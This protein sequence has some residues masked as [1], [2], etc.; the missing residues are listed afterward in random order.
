MPPLANCKGFPSG[1][2]I[3]LLDSG[4]LLLIRLARASTEDVNLDKAVV[5]ELN[6]LMFLLS[7]L[8]IALESSLLLL[9][10]VAVASFS[11]ASA[12]TVAAA[13][14]LASGLSGV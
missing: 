9:A 7:S 10:F 4:F 1:P 6:A 3:V 8:A 14:V 2:K 13:F 12:I 5:L 11:A